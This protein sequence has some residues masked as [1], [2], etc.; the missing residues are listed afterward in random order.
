MK[1]YLSSAIVGM[2]GISNMMV[3][4]IHIDIASMANNKARSH[5][6]AHTYT[7]AH[8]HAYLKKYDKSNDEKMFTQIDHELL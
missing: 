2:L 3:H 5:S 1:I 7:T 4:G 8:S 6:N